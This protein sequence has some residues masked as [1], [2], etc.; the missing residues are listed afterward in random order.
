MFL[1]E[2]CLSLLTKYCSLLRYLGALQELSDFVAFEVA[3]MLTLCAC[4]D[5]SPADCASLLCHPQVTTLKPDGFEPTIVKETN[6]YLYLE[7]ESPFFGVSCCI[8]LFIRYFGPVE[9]CHLTQ[10]AGGPSESL[11]AISFQNL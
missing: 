4:D 2:F 7:Y 11:I 10:N 1:S 8:Y 6:D 5:A 3:S 9:T